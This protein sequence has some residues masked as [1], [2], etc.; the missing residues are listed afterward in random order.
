MI[1]TDFETAILDPEFAMPGELDAPAPVEAWP[2]RA[3]RRIL[4]LERRISQ[5]QATVLRLINVLEIRGLDVDG[6]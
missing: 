4:S 5:L 2:E 1:D 6:E 3:D